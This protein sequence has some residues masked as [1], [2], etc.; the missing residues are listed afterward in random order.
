MNFPL[1]IAAIFKKI[2]T[3]N[4]NM[5]SSGRK[6]VALN[7]DDETVLQALR[8]AL[9][10]SKGVPARSLDIV[11][12]IVSQWPYFDRLAGLDLLRCMA[13]YPAV[14]QF[15]DQRISSLVNLAVE[16]SL[17]RDK[18]PSENAVMM[19]VRIFANMFATADGRSLASSEAETVISVL[20]RVAGLKGGAAIGKFNRN[21]LIATCTAALNYSVLISREKL[22]TPNLRSRLLDVIGATME[23]QA[24]SEVL[25]RALVAIGTIIHACPEVSKGKDVAGWVKQVSSASELR[26]REVAKEVVCLIR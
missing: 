18:E 12:R 23:S 19:G 15:S 1:T 17:P 14:A 8:E 5:V 21:M 7:P 22:L 25:Y 3:I 4:K 26:V 20:E 11:V 16:A 6:D 24:D 9:E 10:T 13:K 2:L